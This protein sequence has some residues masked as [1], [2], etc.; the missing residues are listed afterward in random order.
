MSQRGKILLGKAGTGKS[1][2]ISLVGKFITQIFSIKY[3]K[4]TVRNIKNG[5]FVNS[6]KRLGD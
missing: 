1:T 2:L 3:G 4:Q 6:V 5:E